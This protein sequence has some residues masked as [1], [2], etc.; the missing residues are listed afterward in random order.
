M[1]QMK[2]FAAARQAGVTDDEISETLHYAM[3]GAAR[4]AWCTIKYIPGIEELNKER[5]TTYA[6]E[7]CQ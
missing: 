7:S 1:S 2:E 4:A 6:M 5:R 3:R